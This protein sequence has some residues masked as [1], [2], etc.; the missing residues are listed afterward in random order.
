MAGVFCILAASASGCG[1]S[2]DDTTASNQDH[3]GV[4]EERIIGAPIGAVPFA[5]WPAGPIAFDGTFATMPLAIWAPQPLGLLAFDIPGVTGLTCGLGAFG[6]DGAF[7]ANP[8]FTAAAITTPFLTG[9]QAGLIA[10][11]APLAF[12]APAVLPGAAVAAPLL[13]PIASTAFLTPAISANALMF[14]GLPATSALSP[15]IIN[16]GFTWPAAMN[17]S[18]INVF[19]ASTAATTAFMSASTATMAATTSIAAANSLAF[20]NMLFPL[21][22]TPAFGAFPATLFW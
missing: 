8:A 22:F 4:A 2:H 21:T 3:V 19:A 1:A 10:P 14:T 6:A 12:T 17:M 9:I 7:I 13:T 5:V 15:M 11:V 16:V 18:A 20:T